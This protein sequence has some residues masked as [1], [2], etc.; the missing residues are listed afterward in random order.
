MAKNFVLIGEAGSGKTELSLSLATGLQK[1]GDKQVYFLDM[2]QTKPFSGQRQRSLFEKKP[3]LRCHG[4]A[5]Y[6]AP[7][8]CRGSCKARRP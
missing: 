5:V 6:D 7:R 8:F 3:E 4:E 1:Y 2:D